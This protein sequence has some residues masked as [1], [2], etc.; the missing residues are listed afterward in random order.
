M[1]TSQVQRHMIRV[2]NWVDPRRLGE[3]SF[4]TLEVIMNYSV[5]E[6]REVIVI[7][8]VDRFGVG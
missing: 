3:E 4:N 7:C 6:R 5:Y 8:E 1:F 2:G